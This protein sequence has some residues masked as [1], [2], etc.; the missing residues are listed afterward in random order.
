[1]FL[2]M[3]FQT[4][5]VVFADEVWQVGE[6]GFGILQGAAGLGG[7]LGAVVIA[8]RGEQPN[9]IRLMIASVVG[10]G[11]FLL[12]F[13]LSPYFLLALPLV[14]A[15][16]VFAG[17]FQILNNTAIQLLIPEEVRGRISGFMMMSFGLTP[18]G[19]LPMAL[20]AQ[21]FGAPTAVA[22]AS[23]VVVIGALLWYFVSATLR[24]VDR[25]VQLALET[26]DSEEAA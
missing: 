17:M 5:L 24:G 7:M 12:A 13:A 26:R 11:S 21:S 18:L 4:L 9:R 25:E 20:F 22:T 3:P 19:T 2:A 1:M 23:A 14:L 15:A 8:R 6:R 10:F 16:N